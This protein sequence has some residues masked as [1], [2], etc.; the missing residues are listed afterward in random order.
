ME[1][2]KSKL[3]GSCLLFCLLATG[4]IVL[5][6]R[7]PLDVGQEQK[8]SQ[9]GNFVREDSPTDMRGSFQNSKST[10]SA[11]PNITY[12]QDQNY[13]GSGKILPEI[14]SGKL[15]ILLRDRPCLESIL[16]SSKFSGFAL[17]AGQITG[18]SL[19]D[20][21]SRKKVLKIIGPTLSG[22]NSVIL[23][24]VTVHGKILGELLFGSLHKSHV[25]HCVSKSYTC[26]TF[27]V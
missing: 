11:P 15:L 27:S 22:I 18:F 16:V 10:Y 17:L 23:S 19:K 3:S 14:F 2:H 24:A 4:G 25:I 21:N 8:Q 7:D 26:K 20:I 12:S 6:E 5:C 1:T 9:R 13:S